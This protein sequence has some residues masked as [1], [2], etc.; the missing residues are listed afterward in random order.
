MDACIGLDCS[1]I[2]L[3]RELQDAHSIV[4]IANVRSS[5]G[6]GCGCGWRELRVSGVMSHWHWAILGMMVG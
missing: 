3:W 5:A 2:R 1:S 4:I 6:V